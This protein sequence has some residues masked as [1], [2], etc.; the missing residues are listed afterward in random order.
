MDKVKSFLTVFVLLFLLTGC[1]KDDSTHSAEHQSV[2]VS[3]EE[4]DREYTLQSTMIGYTGIGGLIDG[5]LNPVLQ[6][7]KGE[8]VKI[9]IINGEL[10]PHDIA[11]ENLGIASN[12][13]IDPGET[14]SIVFEAVE[15]DT[16]YCTIPG[17]REAGMAGQF[18]VV[19]ML[20][21]EVFA[22]GILP[23]KDGRPLNLDFE[24]GTLDDWSFTG[25][26]FADQPVLKTDST[27]FGENV[28][29]GHTGN[30]FMSSGGQKEFQR[31]GTMTSVPFE[32]THPFAVFWVSGGALERT[33]VEIVLAAHREI[34]FSITGNNHSALR[35]VV[36]NLEEHMGRDIYI[37][38]IDNETGES[39]ISYIRG[40]V[41][42]HIN[43][44][45]FRFYSE[46]PVFINELR[47]EDI[48][49]LPMRDIVGNT[50]GLSGEDAAR[51]MEV[52]DGFTVRL[53]ASE[54]DVVRPIAMAMDD[55]GRV[56]IAEGHTYPQRA[57]EGEG[58]DR[59]LIFEDTNGDGN[60]DSRKVF[61]EGLNLVSGI[62]VGFGGLWVGAA[63]YLMFIPMDSETDRPAGEPE[64]LLDGWGYQDTHETL[65]SF[66]WGPDGWLYGVHGIFTHSNVGKPGAPDHQRQRINA[67]VWRYHPLRHQ[68]EI[69]AHGTSNPWGIDFNDVGHAF[70][71]VCV[72][73]HLFHVIPG[74]RYHRQA[75]EH[76]NP[77]T[78]DDIKTIADHVHYT[79]NRGP[80]AGN[81]RSASA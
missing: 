30:Y 69:V 57:P 65:N 20:A 4:I 51:A 19:E 80:H 66:R 75:G 28:N 74:A 68:F 81:F 64:I 17:H 29:I 60:L 77:Y 25:D 33:R 42:A 10:M 71:T 52:P 56:W 37:R 14:T 38:I 26:S 44:D 41:W 24:T 1:K 2:S 70:T 8:I 9:T 54:P 12:V 72:I 6:A 48:V 78:Y 55:R 45:D 16:Y 11:L 50:E 32:V 76:F 27:L 3:S 31:T 46:R 62:E 58:K 73:P 39:G 63:P 35:P 22:E 47:P 15:N 21:G 43:F 7:K 40:D 67:G 13:I 36:V 79:G 34:I 61:M 49:V 18:E 53:A 23:E 5:V 59:I